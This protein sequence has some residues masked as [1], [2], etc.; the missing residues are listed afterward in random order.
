MIEAFGS[1]PSE[2]PPTFS[3]HVFGLHEIA[4]LSLHLNNMIPG[5]KA[6]GLQ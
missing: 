5:K 4:A 6:N 2:N 1:F 3:A